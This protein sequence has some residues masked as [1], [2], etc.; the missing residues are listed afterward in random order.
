MLTFNLKKEWF[1]KIKS[2][3][4]TH[5]YREYNDYWITRINNVLLKDKEPLCCFACGYPSKDDK[6]KRL[7]GKITNVQIIE[8]KHSDLKIDKLVFNIWFELVS[9]CEV[10]DKIKTVDLGFWDKNGEYKEDI[11]IFDII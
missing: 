5:E 8:G 3:E 2:G 7:Y 6:T 4:K 10:G 1:E 9:E 11:Q